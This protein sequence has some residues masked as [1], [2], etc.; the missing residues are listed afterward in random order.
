M[1]FEM[2]KASGNIIYKPYEVYRGDRRDSSSLVK[3]PEDLPELPSPGEGSSRLR[4][5][6]ST[7]YLMEV[8]KPEVEGKGKAR[9]MALASVQASGKLLGKFVSGTMVDVPLAAAE[10][11]RMLPGLYGEN[12]REPERVTDWK[13]GM[14]TGA[15]TFAIGMT[16]S[17]VDPLYQ[18]YKG[19][20]D[21]GPL[22]FA[23]G[24][25][26]GTVGMIAKM[27]H[28]KILVL[29]CFKMPVFCSDRSC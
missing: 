22:G 16:E 6:R 14:L 12:I 13:S 18:P 3:S 5:S 24:L 25:V 9:A 8:N 20:R 19:A 1:F 23:G 17:C 29:C 21:G 10:G 26:K 28:G 11:F 15:K 27:G 7:T 4:K 2:L